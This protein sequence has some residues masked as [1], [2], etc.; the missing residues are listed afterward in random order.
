MIRI[1]VRLSKYAEKF[2]KK[3]DRVTEKRIRAALKKLEEEPPQGD[4]KQLK[5]YDELFRLTIGNY[6]AIFCIGK[7]IIEVTDIEPRGQVYKNL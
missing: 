5:G 4:I 1:K 2:L 3:T 7:D 6:R